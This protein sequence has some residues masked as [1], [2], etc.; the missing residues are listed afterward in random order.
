[1]GS[2]RG[3]E[4]DGHDADGGEP[5]ISVQRRPA[6]L[7]SNSSAR[8]PIA[9]PS[10]GRLLPVGLKFSAGCCPSLDDKAVRANLKV[11]QEDKAE[12]PASLAIT[13]VYFP[14][15]AV[16]VRA[17]PAR[18]LSVRGIYIYILERAPHVW[19]LRRFQSGRGGYKSPSELT[20]TQRRRFSSSAASALPGIS[21]TS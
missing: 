18:S 10:P 6:F 11:R 21:R 15:L 3:F 14:L 12:I 1:M 4:E 19:T 8:Y 5:L 16:L 20:A 13:G 2:H 9:S 17:N 7:R